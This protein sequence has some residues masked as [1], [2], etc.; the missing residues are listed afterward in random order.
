MPANFGASQGQLL[1][2]IS[3]AASVHTVLNTIPDSAGS[4]NALK[5]YES[6]R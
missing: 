4:Q 1:R 3:L 5:K 2:L 6:P